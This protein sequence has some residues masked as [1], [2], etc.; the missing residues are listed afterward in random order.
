MADRSPP[1][2]RWN[3]GAAQ[4]RLTV[5][6][7]ADEWRSM[8][9]T[10]ANGADPAPPSI[11]CA[12]P[13]YNAAPLPDE[14]TAA[15]RHLS[16]ASDETRLGLQHLPTQAWQSSGCNQ[17]VKYSTTRKLLGVVGYPSLALTAVF[18]VA[19]CAFPALH[20]AALATL[21]LGASLVG[22]G[23][24]LV[25]R[26]ARRRLRRGICPECGCATERS[27]GGDTFIC[28]QCGFRFPPSRTLIHSKDAARDETPNR[29]H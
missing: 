22:V 9:Q 7:M 3:R 19:G 28:G 27:G 16:A 12:G 18:T 25:D 20:L 11:G 29:S 4:H 5:G 13:W 1:D 17:I 6:R 8:R 15:D 10:S 2:G 23:S 14:E 24:M 21:L 26:S